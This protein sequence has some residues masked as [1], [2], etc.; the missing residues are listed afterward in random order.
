[1]ARIG[2][3]FLSATA[4]DCLS[5][6][7]TLQT[8]LHGVKPGAVIDL[9]EVWGEGGA[10]VEDV[11]R[12][13][14][15]HCDAYLGLFAHRYG[16]IPEK[17]TLS[18]T[19]LEFAWAAHRWRDD[20]AAPIF[21]LLPKKLSSAWEELAALAQQ[22]FDEDQASDDERA[23]SQRLQQEFLADVARW[24]EGRTVVY[25]TG[26]QDIRHLA[27]RCV[28]NWELASLE[29]APLTAR[30]A[31]GVLPEAELGRIGRQPQ[32]DTLAAARRAL[33]RDRT[34]AAAGF[35]VHGQPNHGQWELAHTLADPGVWG[36]SVKPLCFI[37]CPNA[38][39]AASDGVAI[40]HW[41]S[42][43]LGQPLA[44][45][46]D[47]E[48]VARLAALLLKRLGQ[49]TLVF[50]QTTLGRQ[51]DRL[52]RFVDGFWQ[53]LQQALAAGVPAGGLAQRL[54]WILVEDAPLAGPAPL[55]LQPLPALQA[56]TEDDVAAWLETLEE[57]CALPLAPAE[58]A[59]IA[60][61]ALL[62]GGRPP[63]V[64]NRLRLHGFWSR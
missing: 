13:R 4:R 64:Y 10:F 52:Q 36:P 33:V 17:H 42:A 31:A 35:V 38:A 62:H 24:S 48:A 46:P 15:L 47:A 18:I 1:M 34:T 23:E 54:F 56:L 50:V 40:A 16:W 29:S 11:C 8:E 22:T 25:F 32:M 19:Q 3:L 60:Q 39:Q 20:P 61:H 49:Q 7:L 30:P 55:P 59:A 53:P 21:V 51:P 43:E 9:Q 26:T 44:G 57:S 37:G 58:V 14:V 63:D 12:R 27:V 5:Y 2:S 41:A 28:H 6:R 45:A